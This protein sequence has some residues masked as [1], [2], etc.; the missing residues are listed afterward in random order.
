MEEQ[1]LGRLVREEKRDNGQ[2]KLPLHGRGTAVRETAAETRG[3][4]G[5]GWLLGSEP[6]TGRIQVVPS[7]DAGPALQVA[8]KGIP[9]QEQG[10]AL[11]A[12]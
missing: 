9:V 3:G 12:V 6:Y 7:G 1:R 8:D 5:E 2:P 10:R 11:A 4:E